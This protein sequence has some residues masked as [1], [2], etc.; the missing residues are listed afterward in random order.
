METPGW[1][2]ACSGVPWSARRR[3]C[4]AAEVLCVAGEAA[5]WPRDC[6]AAD[7]C[8][9]LRGCVSAS[10]ERMLALRPPGLAWAEE[11]AAPRS[12]DDDDAVVKSSPCSMAAR[13]TRDGWE[14]RCDWPARV[15]VAEEDGWVEAG[16]AADA[17]ASTTADTAA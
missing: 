5:P 16:A 10:L 13:T 7:A 12:M 17:A 8:P 2:S 6:A 1:S 3:A 9:G 14:V 11:L 4:P 15:P